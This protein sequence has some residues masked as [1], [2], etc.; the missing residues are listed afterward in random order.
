MSHSHIQPAPGISVESNPVRRLFVWTWVTRLAGFFERS[1]DRVPAFAFGI[2]VLVLMLLSASIR[3]GRSCSSRGRAI[4]T[5]LPFTA[6]FAAESLRRRKSRDRPH[7]V[8]AA[9]IVI[10]HRQLG[11]CFHRLVDSTR[12]PSFHFSEPLSLLGW[13]L[14]VAVVLLSVTAFTW[15]VGCPVC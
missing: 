13:G 7:N 5:P 8:P 15:A 14:S 3:K 1:S 2:A 9:R 6:K 10:R 4:H 11:R 12:I